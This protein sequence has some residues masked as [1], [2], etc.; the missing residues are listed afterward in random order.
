MMSLPDT[1][2]LKEKIVGSQNGLS[3]FTTQARP[4]SRMIRVISAS[5]NPHWRALRC[6][7]AGSFPLRIEMKMM[8]SMPRTISSTVNV[9]KLIQISGLEIHSIAAR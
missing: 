3:S 7:A 8:L 6:W 1:A 5:P 2:S 9:N 4:H